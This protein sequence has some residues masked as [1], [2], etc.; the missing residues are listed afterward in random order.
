M[1]SDDLFIRKFRRQNMRPPIATV[2]FD[3][4]REAGV[5]EWPPRR[6]TDVVDGESLTPSRVGLT[7][8][9]VG[10]GPHHAEE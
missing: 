2:N 7:L 6:E 9:S 1:Q 4:K 3:P 10:R 5:V 8:R